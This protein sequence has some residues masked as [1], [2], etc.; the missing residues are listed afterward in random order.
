MCTVL[1]PP[2][3]NAIAVNK[4]IKV[5]LVSLLSV[6]SPV[7]LVLYSFSRH[8]CSEW[9]LYETESGHWAAKHLQ[10]FCVKLRENGEIFQ[11]LSWGDTQTNSVAC[12]E[13]PVFVLGHKRAHTEPQQQLLVRSARRCSPLRTEQP[14]LYTTIIINDLSYNM[15][16]KLSFRLQL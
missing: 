11:K 13:A 14:H 2:S 9:W 12:S 15:L 5:S 3:D 1:L 10:N 8:H 7:S 4:Y 6:V 16:S